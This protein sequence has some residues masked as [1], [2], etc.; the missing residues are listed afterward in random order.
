MQRHRFLSPLSLALSAWLLAVTLTPFCLAQ[1]K[2]A[3]T[4]AAQ[5][6]RQLLSVQFL[7]IK[8]GMGAAWREFRQKESLPML[9]KAGT[10]QQT[11]Y[12]SSMFGDGGYMLI[13]PIENLAQFDGQAPPLRALGEEGARAYRAKSQSFIESSH[14]IVIE[15]R[16]ELNIPTKPGE[17]PKLLVLYLNTIEQGF[18]T[19]FENFVKTK[20]LPLVKRAGPRGFRVSR[21]VF[22]GNTN[23]YR[24]AV[25]FDSYEELAKYRAALSKEMTTAKFASKGV[26]IVSRENAIYRFVPELSIVPAPAT[27]ASK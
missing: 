19:D 1:A 27:T 13:T 5:P 2:T 11:V 25:L 22:G 6:P 10:K 15:T 18:N 14:T 3:E 17:Q 4:P 12:Q 26:G 8:P 20:V 7:R 24:E 21:V 16:P 9:Q 23:I